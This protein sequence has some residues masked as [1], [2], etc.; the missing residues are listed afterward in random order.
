MLVLFFIVLGFDSI[1]GIEH[2]LFY[3]WFILMNS[4]AFYLSIWEKYIIVEFILS[5]FNG[6]S[7]GMIILVFFWNFLLELMDEN[8]GLGNLNYLILI[9]NL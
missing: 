7:D 6:V 8:C 1:I 5:I 2:I 9:Y 3:N 4:S